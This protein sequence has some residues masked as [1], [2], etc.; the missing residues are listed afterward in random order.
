MDYSLAKRSPAGLQLHRLV[1]GVVRA[2]LVGLHL[3]PRS[4]GPLVAA[5]GYSKPPG[6]AR[7][8]AVLSLL[9]A[10]APG[11][12]TRA[13][14]D[15]P[16]WA[17]L[18]PSVLTAVSHF[19]SLPASPKEAAARGHAAWLLDRAATYLQVHARLAEARP[20]S[21]RAVAISEAVYPAGA[22][23]LAERAEAIKRRGQTGG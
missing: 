5:G 15:W 10:D 17:V 23:P 6:G 8:G 13:P 1:Q 9:C 11:T 3:G 20:L 4:P 7:L 12:I 18:L 16:R 2:R 22:R 21:E 14:Q 19:D